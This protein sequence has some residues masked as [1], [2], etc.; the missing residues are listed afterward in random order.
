MVAGASARLARECG[1]RCGHFTSA[2]AIACWYQVTVTGP[3]A[4]HAAAGSTVPGSSAL[5]VVT[6]RCMACAVTQLESRVSVL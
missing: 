2:Y 5:V 6:C 3:G 1:A 4:A